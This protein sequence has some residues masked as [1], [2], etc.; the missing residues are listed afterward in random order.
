M[1]TVSN[2]MINFGNKEQSLKHSLIKKL[3]LLGFIL[4]ASMMAILLYQYTIG[5]DQATEMAS[6]LDA[7]I[8]QRQ[9]KEIPDESVLKLSSTIAYREWQFLPEIIRNTVGEKER[10]LKDPFIDGI[11]LREGVE[12]YFSILA[13][14]T[15]SEETLYL[16]SEYPY[17]DLDLLLSEYLTMVMTYS[18]WTLLSFVVL[19]F[20][21]TVLWMRQ[22]GLPFTQMQRWAEK[23]GKDNAQPRESYRYKEFNQLALQLESSMNRVMAFNDRENQFLRHASH[24]LRTPL[25]IIQ[26][27]L[28]TLQEQYIDDKRLSRIRYAVNNM[29]TI[30]V[31][32]LWLAR[33]SKEP[34][35]NTKINLHSKCKDI[36]GDLDY[37]K[38][39][40]SISVSVSGESE[41]VEHAPLVHITLENLIRNS[42]Q[43]STDGIINIQI[44]DHG[45]V[46]SNPHEHDCNTYGFGLGID[47][48]ERICQKQKWSLKIS[49]NTH[50]FQANI[51]FNG[52]ATV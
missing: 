13:Y 37:L 41:I 30:S 21:L 26:A 38:Q 28:D 12:H 51:S 35:E 50:Q 24:E 48:V 25:A 31:T 17:A 3:L 7:R 11:Y 23:L 19:L 32:L 52:A 10:L 29:Q 14:P 40:K 6:K 42:Y 27:T 8:M 49:R 15:E 43:H 4:F 1:I 44:H 46:I 47:L 16:V 5:I 18:F 22:L 20:F 34:L 45:L 2:L 9:F 36:V 39:N 33:E